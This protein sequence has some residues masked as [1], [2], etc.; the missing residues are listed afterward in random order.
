ML[1]PLSLS[2]RRRPPQGSR[3]HGTNVPRLP[4]TAA[5]SQGSRQHGT[6]APRLPY[7]F[8]IRST[9]YPHP[10][11]IGLASAVFVA[12]VRPAPAAGHRLHNSIGACPPFVAAPRQGCQAEQR[13]PSARYLSCFFGVV[14]GGSAIRGHCGA[15]TRQEPPPPWCTLE[16]QADTALE[17]SG[18]AG[19]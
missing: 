18:A 4:Y 14:Q 17:E 13:V 10:V 7:T 3:Q 8:P 19:H 5:T 2:G 6:N 11:R 12:S 1:M 16:S 9:V 15:P